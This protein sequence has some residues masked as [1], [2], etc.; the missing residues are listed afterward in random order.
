MKAASWDLSVGFHG[1]R[2]AP[3]F[4]SR[5]FRAATPIPIHG[6]RS[7]LEDFAEF[8]VFA[9]LGQPTSIRATT[10]MLDSLEML[11]RDMPKR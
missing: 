1:Y 3:V 4:F 8:D 9:N 6:R 5:H 7:S 11:M 2:S 10:G